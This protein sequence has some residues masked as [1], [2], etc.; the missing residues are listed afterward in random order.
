MICL[1]AVLGMM[2]D[3]ARDPSFWH[4]LAPDEVATASTLPQIEPSQAAWQEAVVP[5]PDDRDAEQHVL[6]EKLL[7]VVSDRA[8][9]GVEEMPAYWRLMN[10]SRAQTFADLQARARQDLLFSQLWSQPETYRGQLLQLRLHVRRAIAHDAP[11]NSAGVPQVYELWGWT[12]DSKSFP[13]VV[14]CNELP[15]GVP[16]GAEIRKEVTFAGYFL[17]LMAYEAYDKARAAPLLIGRIQAL[18]DLPTASVERGR[19]GREFW[20]FFVL[21]GATFLGVCLFSRRRKLPTSPEASHVFD[22]QAWQL[23][24]SFAG[25]DDVNSIDVGEVASSDAKNSD[26]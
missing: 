11:K 18:P 2:I 1:A 25:L 5:G 16:L 26:A 21:G 3:R 13:Y 17:K 19:N 12:D 7:D 8:S 14:L 22:P 9:I 23:A 24:P 4:W 15:P 20:G 6:G 10:W